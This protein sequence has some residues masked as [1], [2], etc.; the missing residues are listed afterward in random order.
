MVLE[1][2]FCRLI[3]PFGELK[4]THPVLG[5]V[6]KFEMV[7]FKNSADNVCVIA[8]PVTLCQRRFQSNILAVVFANIQLYDSLRAVSSLPIF[9]V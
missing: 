8:F 7:S 5:N 2:L 6:T 3:Y 4:E 1:V 9:V